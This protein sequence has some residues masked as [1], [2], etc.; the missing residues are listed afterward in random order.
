MALVP[1]LCAFYLW[2]VS[3][4]QSPCFCC[5]GILHEFGWNW[6]QSCIPLSCSALGPIST[7]FFTYRGGIFCWHFAAHGVHQFFFGIVR[8][9]IRTRSRDLI[10]INIFQPLCHAE[11]V[12]PLALP[13]EIGKRPLQVGIRRRWLIPRSFPPLVSREH[14]RFR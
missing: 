2:S 6:Q 3:L 1:Q 10:F 5:L 9:L 7:Y 11:R 12:P 8:L 13:V 4:D 14:C